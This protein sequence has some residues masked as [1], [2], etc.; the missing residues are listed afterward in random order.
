[1]AIDLNDRGLQC[2][3]W[4]NI[5]WSG[6]AVWQLNKYSKTWHLSGPL[7]VARRRRRPKP[8]F[9]HQNF[10]LEI[11]R[12]GVWIWIIEDRCVNLNYRGPVCEFELTRNSYCVWN[13]WTGMVSSTTAGKKRRRKSNQ[14]WDFFHLYYQGPVCELIGQNWQEGKERKKERKKASRS[15]STYWYT[16]GLDICEYIK[17]VRIPL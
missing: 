14:H 2:D 8:A 13:D 5:I 6:T 3:N 12:T 9:T 10:Q 11:S 4:T 17:L 16:T 7:L 15:R 1:M